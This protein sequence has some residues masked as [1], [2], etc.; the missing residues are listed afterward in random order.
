MNR[1]KQLGTNRKLFARGSG[2]SCIGVWE[3]W[4]YGMVGGIWG[5]WGTWGW[6]R[7]GRD[8]G[9]GYGGGV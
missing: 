3:V 7:W 4:E 2:G 9:W 1:S 8:M 6:G 5:G